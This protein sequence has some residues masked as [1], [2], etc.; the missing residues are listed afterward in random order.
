MFKNA[1]SVVLAIAKL[2]LLFI[3]Y[4]FFGT[5]VKVKIKMFDNNY[6]KFDSIYSMSTLIGFAMVVTFLNISILFY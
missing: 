5:I 6:S 1:P 4:C 3:K 2:K